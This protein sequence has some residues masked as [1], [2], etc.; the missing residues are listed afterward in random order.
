MREQQ[1]SLTSTAS[2]RASDTSLGRVQHLRRL[3]WK[4]QYL[5]FNRLVELINRVF[6]RLKDNLPAVAVSRIKILWLSM[7][8]TACPLV[9]HARVRLVPEWAPGWQAVELRNARRTYWTTSRSIGSIYQ[10]CLG[11]SEA[12]FICRKPKRKGK[13]R[14]VRSCMPSGASR[15]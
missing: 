9:P 6:L 1:L 2:A 14:N 4:S 3:W 11:H 5:C 15:F 12:A 7:I 8:R 10:L 13:R